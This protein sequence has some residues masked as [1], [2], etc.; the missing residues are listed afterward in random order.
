VP[1]LRRLKSH[2]HQRKT[3]DQH[4]A[5]A[6]LDRRRDGD[7]S[8]LLEVR[9]VEVAL[10]RDTVEIEQFPAELVADLSEC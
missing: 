6:S 1:C 5:D 4:L 8:R 2:S 7:M 9:L 3:S 10:G